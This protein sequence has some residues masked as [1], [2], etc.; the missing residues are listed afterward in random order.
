MAN[1]SDKI[2]LYY[3]PSDPDDHFLDIPR[4]D[5]TEADM[6]SLTPAQMRNA[7]APHP[8]TGKPMYQPTKPSGARAEIAQQAMTA[9]APP[10]SA[11][12]ASDQLAA[13][14]PATAPAER[15]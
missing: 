3:A 8:V 11:P 5:L 10:A 14:S 13:A 4:R 6:A 9:P 1:D 2:A 15:V 7:T 12:T